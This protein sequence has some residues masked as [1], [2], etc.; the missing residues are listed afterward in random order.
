MHAKQCLRLGALASFVIRV[1]ARGRLHL[2]A[3]AYCAQTELELAWGIRADRLF[4]RIVDELDETVS[5]R[6]FGRHTPEDVRAAL[7]A[8]CPRLAALATGSRLSR[9]PRR[10]DRPWVDEGKATT[11]PRRSQ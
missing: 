7:T 8:E 2:E 10:P 11:A 9:P 6:S 4:D 3:Q 5:G 1:G